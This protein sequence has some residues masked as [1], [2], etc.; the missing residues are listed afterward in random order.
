MP[1]DP[2]ASYR[3]IH[4]SSFSI[5]S[6]PPPERGFCI[7][8][9]VGACRCRGADKVDGFPT[10]TDCNTPTTSCARTI[11]AQTRVAPALTEYGDCAAV[12]QIPVV[13]PDN[14]EHP[15]SPPAADHTRNATLTRR[16]LYVIVSVLMTVGILGYLFQFVRLEDIVSTIVNMNRSALLGFV[17]LSI[18]MSVCRTWRY[19]LMLRLSGFRPGRVA[20]FLVVVVRNFFSDM[21]PARIGTLVYVYLVTNRL[22]VPFGAAASSFAL[23]FLFDILALAPLV[24]G[25][26]MIAGN[27]GG[28]SGIALG[29]SAVILLAVTLVILGV[30]PRIA[31]LVSTGI[32]R[33]GAFPEH[34]RYRLA[35]ALDDT[36]LELERIRQSGAY[37]KL[38]AISI[39][40]RLAK[41]GS[42]YMLL[43]AMVEPMGYALGDL[44]PPK[45]FLGLVAPELAAS[46]PISGI[47]GFGAYE[48]TWAFMFNLLLFPMELAKLTAITHHLF[49]QVYGALLGAV[50]LLILITPV[51]P[52][53]TD[54][55]NPVES[56]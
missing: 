19:L 10:F 13:A 16:R 44:P 15:M 52:W 54:R 47:A 50:A 22:G 43:Y 55:G 29:V 14:H 53:R 18:A 30:L 23:A 24:L 36:A 25:A 34:T 2:V 9:L 1:P 33:M 46:L 56:R 49:T 8:A 32:R 42:L 38:L 37:W 35:S 4:M 20:V 41:Y 31:R 51:F 48:G 11:P 6:H 45:V 26:A 21:L 12:R 17:A 5:G 39:L 28:L 7:P 3:V 40:V 27:V